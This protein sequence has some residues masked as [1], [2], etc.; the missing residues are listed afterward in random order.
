MKA[1]LFSMLLCALLAGCGLGEVAV[2]TAV[3]GAT[4]AEQ[5]KQA[6]QLKARVTRELDAAAQADQQRRQ[7]AEAAAQ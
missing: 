6:P 1:P 7:A 2:S 4:Q 3:S 5:A